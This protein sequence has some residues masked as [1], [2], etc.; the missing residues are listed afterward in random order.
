MYCK[1]CGLKINDTA[2]FC[3]IC[4]DKRNK[5]Q[6]QEIYNNIN[7]NEIKYKL[8]PK[9]KILYRLLKNVSNVAICELMV[10]CIFA[11]KIYYKLF[12]EPLLFLLMIIIGLAIITI[13][14]KK[15]HD[16]MEYNFFNTKIEYRD[17]F[18]YKEEKELKYKYIR[19]IKISQSLME[20]MF[21]IGTIQIYT[22][23]SNNPN[24]IYIHC[25][26]NIFEQYIIIKQIID[27][28]GN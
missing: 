6:S 7:D 25:V 13:F 20:R 14:E 28:G 10:V 5:N 24:G 27:S 9:Y 1:K 11:P 8:K 12:N 18:L 3:P 21:G 16:N 19:E 4:G 23:A 22:N 15:R 26:E 2:K 17:G